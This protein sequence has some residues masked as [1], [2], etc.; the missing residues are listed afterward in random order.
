MRVL[1]PALLLV[2]SALPLH[3][4]DWS[5]VVKRI[6][7]SVVYVQSED[8]SCTGFVVDVTKKYVVTAEHCYGKE[9][10]VDLTP[11]TVIAR[12]SHQDL[13]VLEVKNLDPGRP[14]LKLAAKDP[15]RGLEVMSA[16]FGYA[17]ESAQ[18]R[19]AH[20]ADNHA[21]IPDIAQDFYTTDATFVG[22]QSGG[23]VV[24]ANCEVV[25]IVQRGSNSVG[26]G[27]GADT[28]RQR[29]GRFFAGQP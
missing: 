10:Y 14:A 27:I 13:M 25:M 1:L 21:R 28:I 26:I 29:I 12:D 3:A 6:E 23:P 8:G 4:A 22:G 9:L 5:D 2:A 18:F 15:D 11:A 20:I 24:N 7:R 16:G 17:L 19:I